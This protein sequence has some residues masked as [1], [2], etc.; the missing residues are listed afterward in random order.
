VAAVV[1]ATAVAGTAA[2]AAAA[3]G[4]TSSSRQVQ[5]GSGEVLQHI[6]SR[7][8]GPAAAEMVS[9]TPGFPGFLVSTPGFPGF[10]V[11]TRSTTIELSGTVRTRFCF[12]LTYAWKSIG[13]SRP[14]PCF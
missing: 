12:S 10:L 5:L 14:K 13:Y 3:G 11:S 6:R 2:A 7:M 8:E 9:A 4:A 1:P